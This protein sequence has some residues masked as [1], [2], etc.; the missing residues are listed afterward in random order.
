MSWVLAALL[1]PVN[2]VEYRYSADGLLF[3]YDTTCLLV[4]NRVLED[5]TA[6]WQTT[7]IAQG[8]HNCDGP[9]WKVKT[10][11]TRKT[12]PASYFLDGDMID[13]G[14]RIPVGAPC[15]G[16]AVKITSAGYWKEVENDGNPLYA[17]CGE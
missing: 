6:E 7:T 8:T 9:Y 17:L 16:P 10:N 12:R 5:R 4:R 11:G 14:K 2:Q 1:W 13:S 15:T 3:K